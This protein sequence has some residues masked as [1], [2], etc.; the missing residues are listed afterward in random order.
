MLSIKRKLGILL[1][2]SL[3]WGCK[4]KGKMWEP[5]GSLVKR[6][7]GLMAHWAKW[8]MGWMAR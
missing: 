7:V 4:E 5:N 6:F 2:L 1:I 3:F 8:F